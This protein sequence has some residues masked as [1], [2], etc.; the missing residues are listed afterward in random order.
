[1]AGAASPDRGAGRSGRTHR[2]TA[3]RTATLGLL[4]ALAMGWPGP[5]AA[6]PVGAGVAGPG[7]GSQATAT[8][9]PAARYE[10]RLEI[11]DI[12]TGARRIVHRGSTRFEAPNWSRDGRHLLINQQGSLYRIPVEGGPPQKL[13]IGSVEGCNNDHGYSPD[14]AWLAIS[15]RPSSS[16]YV[17]AAEG[18]AP[19]LLTSLVPSYWHGWSPDGATLA[20]VGQR[21]GE[22]D[23]Y[24]MPVGG[25][26]ERRLTTTP[27]LDDGP[28]YTPDGQWIYF[29]SVRT[30]TMRIWRMRPD[31]ADQQQVT[32]DAQYADWF[33]HPS[34]DGKWLVWV[35]FDA[36][37][38]GHPPYKDVVLRLMPLGD[39]PGTPRVLFPLFGGQGTINV[40]SWS[41]DSTQVAFVS[42]APL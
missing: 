30:G 37:V 41:P 9:A 5:A 15:C 42:Y 33:P 22:Y 14:G 29:N 16:V 35:S 24:T 4:T 1:L 36:S 3:A 23:I 26:A 13:D 7:G 17:V 19:R 27:G 10:S 25:G 21:L 39:A 38:D 40:P 12:R 31:G 34:P 2:R 11:V 28:D 6:Q 32:F 8:A 20:Y 18:G